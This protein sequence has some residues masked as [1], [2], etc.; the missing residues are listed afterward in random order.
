M[1]KK[2]ELP[3]LM[4]CVMITNIEGNG[5]SKHVCINCVEGYTKSLPKYLG[6]TYHPANQYKQC[7]VCHSYTKEGLEWLKKTKK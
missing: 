6:Y 5:F 1:D 4:F 7:Q 2:K 3:S